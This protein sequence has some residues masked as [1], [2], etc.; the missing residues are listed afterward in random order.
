MPELT[1]CSV[2][3]CPLVPPFVSHLTLLAE[4]E[5]LTPLKRI[6]MKSRFVR[7]RQI[8]IFWNHR[9]HRT[10]KHTHTHT[11][12]D[13]VLFQCRNKWKF[14]PQIIHNQLLNLWKLQKLSPNELPRINWPLRAC[15]RS[16]HSCLW[17]EIHWFLMRFV[18][19]DFSATFKTDSK[20]Y[21]KTCK[22]INQSLTSVHCQSYTHRHTRRHTHVHTHTPSEVQQAIIWQV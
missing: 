11:H 13:N 5:I 14:L 20:V 10:L 1:P 2:L 21:Y 19:T 8:H 15:N 3:P 16:P 4:E 9:I 22:N 12:E 18:D 17:R 7:F 6:V